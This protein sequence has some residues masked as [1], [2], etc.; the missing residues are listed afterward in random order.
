MQLTI[1]CVLMQDT[2]Q[3]LDT[4]D[5]LS[6][7]NR[8]ISKSGNHIIEF[9]NVSFKYENSSVYALK[10]ISLI[11]KEN[12]TY[13]FVGMNGSGKTTMIKLLCRLYDPASGFITLDNIDIKE[14]D[15]KEYMKFFSVV[16]QDFKLFSLSLAQNIA[17]SNIYNEDDVLDCIEKAGFKERY[18][19]MPNGMQ[20]LIYKDMGKEGVEISG[21]EEQKIAI[22]RALYK[23]SPFIILD[24]P[25][26]A[27]DPISEFEIYSRFNELKK[28]KTTIFISHRLSSCR[29]CT[30]IVVFDE[31]SIVQMGSHDFLIEDKKGKYYKLWNA[32]SKYYN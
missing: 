23:N 5:S 9:H 6:K 1:S 32:Q 7:G 31:G 12:E 8:R 24:E 25:T 4:P 28:N 15:Y 16:F 21:G 17:V 18:E 19:K 29:F 10:N 26:A 11:L 27:L 20:S 2:V 3:F 22:A 30:D 13:A 14:Y